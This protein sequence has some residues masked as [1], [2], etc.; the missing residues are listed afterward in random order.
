[1]DSHR[2][3]NLVANIEAPDTVATFGVEVAQGGESLCQEGVILGV[4]GDPEPLEHGINL[5]ARG[6][7]VGVLFSPVGHGGDQLVERVRIAQRVQREGQSAGDGEQGRVL[8]IGQVNTVGVDGEDVF[9]V[10]TGLIPLHGIPQVHRH[11][12]V[13][14]VVEVLAE[15]EEVGHAGQ[16]DGHRVD[17]EAEHV[18]LDVLDDLGGVPPG[19]FGSCDDPSDCLEEEGARP[20][21]WVEGGL[22][23]WLVQHLGGDPFGQPVG[24]VVLAHAFTHVG[25]DD[26]L[27]E[28]FQRVVVNVRPVEHLDALHG[29]GE[30]LLAAVGQENPVEEPGLDDVVDPGLPELVTAKQAFGVLDQVVEGKAHHG[31]TDHGGFHE[32]RQC[33]MTRIDALRKYDVSNKIECILWER[34]TVQPYE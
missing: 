33:N 9:L 32:N 7:G 34:V 23:Q 1:M 19:S 14:T 17:V 5:R 30:V 10:V 12:Y 29:A 22:L 13:P 15:G 26:R 20:A 3:A 25:V 31:M 8:D 24:G 2:G 27:V 4:R 6:C 21:G 11:P 18:V 28:D 16:K